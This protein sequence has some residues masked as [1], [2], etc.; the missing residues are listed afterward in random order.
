MPWTKVRWTIWSI[1]APRCPAPAPAPARRYGS[2]LV[3]C[4]PALGAESSKP[5]LHWRLARSEAGGEQTVSWR[6]R[7][8]AVLTVGWCYV[9]CTPATLHR[10]HCESWSVKLSSAERFSVC[11]NHF[12]FPWLLREGDW[13]QLDRD[14]GVRPHHELPLTGMVS[15][16]QRMPT[17]VWI[18]I[19][20]Q[21]LCLHT[22]CYQCY[23]VMYLFADVD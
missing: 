23:H 4:E 21:S 10:R 5:F 18:F 17:S 19:Y 16:E 20:G 1:S 7:L 22:Q 11:L 2:W 9:I 6:K 13:A 15:T 12:N 8:S 3:R 14:T